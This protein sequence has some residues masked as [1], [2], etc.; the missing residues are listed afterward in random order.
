MVGRF[1]YKNFK[2][3]YFGLE[4]RWVVGRVGCFIGIVVNLYSSVL[5]VVSIVV[6]VVV[7]EVDVESLVGMVGYRVW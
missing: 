5:E 3:V 2:Y 4:W 7:L 6:G 1:V